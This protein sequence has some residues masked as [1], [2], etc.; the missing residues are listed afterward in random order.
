MTGHTGYLMVLGGFPG[1]II[2]FHDV[3]TIA[4]GGTHAVEE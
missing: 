1:F 4:E 2:G 3:A